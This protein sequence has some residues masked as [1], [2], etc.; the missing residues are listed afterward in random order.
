MS[1][2]CFIMATWQ[3]PSDKC[4][5][6][7][8]RSVR[9]PRE[10]GHGSVWIGRWKE[11]DISDSLLWEREWGPFLGELLT[12]ARLSS[13]STLIAKTVAI[14]IDWLSVLVL[15]F[16][17][18]YLDVRLTLLPLNLYRPPVTHKCIKSRP[19]ATLRGCFSTCL[20]RQP[21]LLSCKTGTGESFS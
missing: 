1:C 16:K 20:A 15:I 17:L 3:P 12:V 4:T 2:S 11:E 5:A 13:A 19:L 18:W 8:R 21:G 7:T 9:R 14:C 6:R 10:R